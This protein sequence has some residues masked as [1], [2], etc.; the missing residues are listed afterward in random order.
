[1]KFFCEYCGNRI[2]AEKDRKCPNCGASYKKNKSFI[3]L[4]QERIEEDKKNKEFKQQV[5]DH[6][7]GAM[8]FSKWF[9]FIPIIIFIIVFSIIIFGFININKDFNNESNEM[10]N[11]FDSV[12]DS[13]TD[14]IDGVIEGEQETQEV[15]VNFNEY[16]TLDEYKVKVSK[17]ETVDD[18]FKKAEEGYE[19]IKFHLLVENLTDGQI[20]KEDV[21][22]IVDGIAQTNYYSS[23]Y[24]D[25]PMFIQKGL[26]VKGTA[27]FLVPEN[28]VSYD[29]RYG[30]YITIH[31]EK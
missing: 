29:I 15:T 31:I 13:I 3:K 25:L 22:C 12:F 16:A 2:D 30:D 1:M 4:Q 18:K 21:N 8:K 6:T 26:T 10:K 24:S 20:I 9:I 19:I 14:K 5:M 28:T 7:L 23:G 17:Y 11:E 27:T